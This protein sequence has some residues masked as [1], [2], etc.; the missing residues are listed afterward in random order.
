[1]RRY[2][3]ISVFLLASFG[4][5]GAPKTSTY[6]AKNGWFTFQYPADASNRTDSDTSTTLS[7][8]EGIAVYVAWLTGVKDS[9]LDKWVA[10]SKKNLG[11][12]ATAGAATKLALGG[13]P[14]R[15]FLFDMVQDGIKIKGILVCAC[16]GSKD[17]VLSLGCPAANW[18][19]DQAKLEGVISSFKWNK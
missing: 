9:Q 2:L 18:K 4:L 5:A 19:A 14:A 8:K 1:M 7:S 10:Q 3:L 6:K 11:S 16:N 12:K 15:R 17:V 13:K